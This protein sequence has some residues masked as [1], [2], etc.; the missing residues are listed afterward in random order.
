VKSN[1]LCEFFRLSVG[2]FWT[3]SFDFESIFLTRDQKEK[4]ATVAASHLTVV[5]SKAAL[6][7]RLC[8][9]EREPPCTC[10]M[11]VSSWT[12]WRAS[13][14]QL[15]G[16]TSGTSQDHRPPP[17]ARRKVREAAVRRK[18]RSAKEKGTRPN[19]ISRCLI[20]A[21]DD[22]LLVRACATIQ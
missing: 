10:C 11:S 1:L 15:Q 17:A 5:L 2:T 13:Q 22:K 12:V 8:V 21:G 19:M 18:V 3:D 9:S 14:L 16:S 20:C 4:G 6:A 7:A